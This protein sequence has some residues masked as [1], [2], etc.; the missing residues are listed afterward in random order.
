MKS[1]KILLL[2]FAS[3]FL[4]SSCSKNQTDKDKTSKENKEKPPKEKSVE[5][6]TNSE[7]AKYDLSSVN[8]VI[9]TLP[10][11]LKEISGM[12]VTPDNRLFCQQDEQG[13]V[14]QVDYNTGSIIKKFSLGSPSIRKDFE[15]IA[16]ANGMFYLMES[17]GDIYEFKE[18]IDGESVEYK[19]YK[20]EL[21]KK[22]DMEGMCYDP[23]TNSLLLATKGSS[24]TG[25]VDDKAVYSFSLDSMK[26]N[27]QPRFILKKSEIKNNFNPSGI[28]F[29]NKTGT[30]FVI[31]ANGN[32]IV[33]ISKSGGFIGKQKLPT[34]IHPQAEGIVFL[35]DNTLLISNEGKSGSGT[36]IV[37]PYKN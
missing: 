6:I 10:N 17:N 1:K 27:L 18:G 30:F 31:A 28:I 29:N 32:E 24:G 22:N 21:S 37:Y 23:E 12:T 19:V 33:E 4:I 7:L 16:F 20:T 2:I 8:P 14:Y 15:D 26:L 35:N 5:N 11:D 25:D 3:I 9:V 34:G 36:I 13:I